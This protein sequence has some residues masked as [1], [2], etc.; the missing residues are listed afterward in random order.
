MG[1]FLWGIET[2][3]L[4]KPDEPNIYLQMQTKWL[5]FIFK[6]LDTYFKLLPL[7]WLRPFAQ[8]R[9]FSEETNRFFSQLTKDSL[10]L[11]A[12]D[13]NS[14]KRV[15]FLNH[16]RQLQEKKGIS[17]DDMVGHILTTML[18][19]FETSA[20]VLFHAIFYVSF[21]SDQNFKV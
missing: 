3:T 9:L 13:V 7:P 17:H 10:D 14:Q 19:G 16:L 20:T 15:D 8:R 2:N 21:S 11:R 6:S 12:R 4:A 1:E 18:D 5:Q